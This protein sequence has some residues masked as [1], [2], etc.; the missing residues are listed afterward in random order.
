[1]K[2]SAKVD[3]GWVDLVATAV[4]KVDGAEL[5]WESVERRKEGEHKCAMHLRCF[6]LLGSA[7]ELVSWWRWSGSCWH[8]WRL[9][10][11]MLDKGQS[12]GNFWIFVVFTHQLFAWFVCGGEKKLL[13]GVWHWLSV[14]SRDFL[15]LLIVTVA[16]WK[17]AVRHAM[18]S[19]SKKEKLLTVKKLDFVLCVVCWRCAS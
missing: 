8:C 19:Q 4:R 9:R 18:T 6:L 5:W 14:D 17:S 16:E 12:A 15:L 1:M 2:C 7:V 11:K 13:C 10:W 3:C